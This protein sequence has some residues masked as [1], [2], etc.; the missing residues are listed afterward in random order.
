M[1]SV[2]NSI[3]ERAVKY[4]KRI[5]LPETDCDRTLQA[6]LTAQEARLADVV[7]VGSPKYVETRGK[8]LGLDL[9]ALEVIDPEDP[10]VRQ[11]CAATYY[12][13]RK[14]KGLTELPTR[15]SAP[16]RS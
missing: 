14:D 15:C 3:R 6:A 8:H 12:E 10:Q 4:H 7:L 11:E 13:V 16:P 9:T 2:I 5:A 1:Q